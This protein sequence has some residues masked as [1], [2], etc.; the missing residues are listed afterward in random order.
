MLQSPGAGGNARRP[1]TVLA[2]AHAGLW[3][4]EVTRPPH[5]DPNEAPE[6][7]NTNRGDSAGDPEGQEQKRQ[8]IDPAD[9]GP[10]TSPIAGDADST[11]GAVTH[12]ALQQP[13]RQAA[14]GPTLLA[15]GGEVAEL[16]APHLAAQEDPPKV[17]TTLSTRVKQA[18]SQGQYLCSI[19]LA[20][21]GDESAAS[22]IK[23]LT[24]HDTPV[25]L[26][27]RASTDQ[28][29]VM[30]GL[31]QQLGCTAC[32]LVEDL[33]AALLDAVLSHCGAI[34]RS[35]ADLTELRERFSLAIRGS[36]DGM[37]EWDLRSSRVFYSSRWRE[38]LGYDEDSVDDTIDAWFHRVHPQDV[39][40]VRAD[41]D[42]HIHGQK[43][44]HEIEHRVRAAD[45]SYHWIL[46][47]AAVHCDSDG[48]PIRVAGS[49]TDI[50][51][52]RQR[53]R[54]L[55]EQS[56]HDSLTNLPKRDVFL[57][58]LARTVELGRQY[59]DFHFA[60]LLVH[61]D[62]IRPIRDSYGQRAA[63]SLLSLLAKRLQKCVRPDDLLARFAPE[64]FALLLE[65]LERASEGTLL[66]E[67]IHKA[68]REPFEIEGARVH[69]SVS[70]GMTSSARSYTS[71]DHVISDVAAAADHARAQA[72]DRNEIFHTSMRV[73]ALNLLHMEIELRD[74]I[75]RQEFQL[76]YQ[77]IVNL[78]D[79]SVIAFEALVRWQHPTRGRIS[80]AEFI[81]T[82]EDTGL[83]VPIGRWAL[84]EASRQLSTWHD[85][86]ELQDSLSISVNL[87]GRQASDPRL[88][89]DIL[90]TLES[91][92]VDPSRL[93]IELTETVLLDNPDRVV[94][95]LEELR[96][97]GI[98][99]WIDDFG[100]GYSS[101]SYLHQ[102]PVD[103]LKIDSSFVKVLDGSAESATMVQ[104][105][106]SLATN[107]GLE[108]VAE[109]IETQ[110]QADHLLALGCS[111]AQGYLFAR[112]LSP[113]DAYAVLARGELP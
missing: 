52:Y 48:T 82:A 59:D 12:M 34:T 44:I 108:V 109:G 70:I 55:R 94:T 20:D 31:S 47:R 54:T 9:S 3:C 38:L 58:R 40:R 95:L 2:P 113:G 63:D 66:A 87:S 85:E 86:F 24:T 26:L 57:E 111:Q 60:V 41:L 25:V 74:A 71:V 68:L 10:P 77:P 28:R 32:I 96:R 110:V 15:V 51:P 80:P 53:E 92:K 23:E 42:A 36:N 56:R 91:T 105:I 27:V 98:K 43:N 17:E 100:T 75:E 69:T 64:K 72:S 45:G 33:S 29:A 99:I 16:L 81:P 49:F 62:R 101:L 65:D 73:E 46:S 89:Q 107:L 1:N 39:V 90:D 8:Q 13:E 83:I 22:Q 78:H 19:L 104:T 14:I 61:A 18:V 6:S 84:N 88:L 11:A 5:A 102:F 97:R 79:R 76:H 35:R 21:P 37:W 4:A 103:G 30:R 112:P 106:L 93:K 7:S 67:R 50:T